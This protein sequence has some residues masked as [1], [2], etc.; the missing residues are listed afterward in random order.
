MIA[1]LYK[2]GQ[3]VCETADFP[4]QRNHLGLFTEMIGLGRTEGFF[5][6]SIMTI[7]ACV[8]YSEEACVEEDTR[9][10]CDPSLPLWEQMY[11]LRPILV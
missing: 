5:F 9:D 6:Q 10:L 11:L 4:M 7:E 2:H 3:K 1:F 8:I